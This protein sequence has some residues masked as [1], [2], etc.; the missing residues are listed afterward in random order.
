M[1]FSL[2]FFIAAFAVALVLTPLVIKFS[3]NGIGLDHADET[4]KTQTTPIPRLGGVSLMVPLTLALLVIFWRRPE[5][6]SHWLPLY[7]GLVLIF[8]L[9]LW[10][11]IRSLRARW[12]LLG[13]IAIA[14]LVYFLGLS[15]DRVTYPL[16]V[17]SVQLGAWSLFATVFWLI[18]VPNVVNLIDGFDGLAWAWS[19]RSRSVS[20][21]C[22]RS[23]C[24]RPGL[25][26]RWPARCSAFFALIFRRHASIWAIV[27]RISSAFLSRAFR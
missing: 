8:A 26:S 12:K 14:V 20:S 4:R 9:G 7:L 19:W 6:I 2:L 22:T 10:D 11:D 1:I 17:W 23:S 3:Q 24:P 13:Q 25:P 21:R 15:I 16:G 18:A 5:Q 27:V